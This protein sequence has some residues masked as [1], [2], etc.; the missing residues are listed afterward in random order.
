MRKKQCAPRQCNHITKSLAVVLPL[1]ACPPVAQYLIREAAAQNSTVSKAASKPNA[2]KAA[3][4]AVVPRPV[5]PS[6]A[7]LAAAR[8]EKADTLLQAQEYDGALTAAEHAVRLQPEWFKGHYYVAYS[9]YKQGKLNAALPHAN[10]AQKLAPAQSQGDVVKLVNAI[11]KKQAVASQIKAGDEAM[12]A[13]L[14]AKAARLYTDVWEANPENDEVGMKAAL[15]WVDRLKRPEEA[16]KILHYLKNNSPDSRF[17]DGVAALLQRVQPALEKT[18]NDKLQAGTQAL[19]QGDMEKALE[20]L[21]VAAQVQPQQQEAHVHLTRVHA[22]QNDI[23]AAIKAFTAVVK[24]GPVDVENT[25]RYQEL[26]PL[27]DNEKFS[28]FLTDALGEAELRAAKKAAKAA[29]Q[30]VAAATDKPVAAAPAN[31]GGAIVITA[32]AEDGFVTS[33]VVVRGRALP[34]SDIG[35][36][37]RITGTQYFVLEFKQELPLQQVRMDKNGVWETPPIELPKPKNVS[38]LR[39]V[40]TAAHHGAAKEAG[41]SVAVD[42]NAAKITVYPMK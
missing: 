3:P 2:S 17:V 28:A 30:D 27:L 6:D 13:G 40:I 42:V 15:L 35:V 29:T 36:T 14:V 33:P 9:L 7:E 20:D 31:T 32:P 24:A 23:A 8:V 10:Q 5:E 11:T 26:G 39:Y 19:A 18:Y 1:I 12:E 16:V 22:K 4:K 25:F 34:G 38:N 21:T 41:E 37:I